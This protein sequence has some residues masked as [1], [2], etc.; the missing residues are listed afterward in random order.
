MI[1]GFIYT[2]NPTL[3]GTFDRRSN[4]LMPKFIQ[5]LIHYNIT[6]DALSNRIGLLI[7]QF[8]PAAADKSLT[9][10]LR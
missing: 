7:D 4:P 1:N 8:N 9:L 2:G 5:L 6:Y 3:A 10:Y